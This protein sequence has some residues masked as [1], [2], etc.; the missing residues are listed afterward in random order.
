M[1]RLRFSEP[2]QRDLKEIASD[3][4]EHS[5]ERAIE[6]VD[7]LERQCQMIAE[8]PKLG[9]NREDLRQNLRSLPCAPYV[10]F[11]YPCDDG[12]SVARI[13]H[14]KRDVERTI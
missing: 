10:I 5:V 2:A 8:M 14:G 9:R 4:A 1:S 3:I 11:Y 12:A 6:L 13:L 7:E